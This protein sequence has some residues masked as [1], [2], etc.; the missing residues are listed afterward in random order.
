MSIKPTLKTELISIIL[1]LLSGVASFY[2]YANFPEKVPL[3]WNMAGEVDGWGSK[4]TGAFMIPEKRT[5]LAANS[6]S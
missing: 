1:L 4:A 5:M 3:H 6:L 2:F